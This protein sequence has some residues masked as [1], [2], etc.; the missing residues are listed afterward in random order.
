MSTKEWLDIVQTI[1]LVATAVFAALQIKSAADQLA[2]AASEYKEAAKQT[3]IAAQTSSAATLSNL[4]AASR[5]I[6]WKVLQD[7]DLHRLLNATASATGLTA[8]QKIEVA[9]GILISHYA[10][11]YEFKV[12]N[13]ITPDIWK[14]FTA[15][16]H[17]YFSQQRVQ[18]R[19]EVLKNSYSPTFRDFVD[20]DLLRHT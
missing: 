3:Q 2:T 19:W 7:A 17:G 9:I 5:E 13:Q 15:D 10:F 14:A 6:Q 1:A 20:K 8:E 12:L 16:M 4:A 18:A 11:T